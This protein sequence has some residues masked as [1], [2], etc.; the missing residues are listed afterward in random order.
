MTR[1]TRNPALLG[2]KQRQIVRLTLIRDEGVAG[3]KFVYAFSNNEVSFTPHRVEAL[4]FGLSE[5]QDV[6]S[7]IVCNG[8]RV[9][10]GMDVRA[11]AI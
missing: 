10:P 5:I 11:E 2:D 6:L 1:L 7:W 4:R 9:F 3:Q 8:H